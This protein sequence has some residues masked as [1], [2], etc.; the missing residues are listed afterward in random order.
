M[1]VNLMMPTV[2]NQTPN[3]AYSVL[4]KL[5]IL[6]LKAFNG[7]RDA[8]EF[9]NFIFDMEQYFKASGTNYEKTKVTLAFMHLSDDAKLWWRSRVNDIQN[10]Q[11]TIDTGKN[12]NKDLVL[13]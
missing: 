8:K 11:C 7:N 12:L 5:K 4:S 3:Q 13:P 1:Q 9:E 10:G 2:G 6:K